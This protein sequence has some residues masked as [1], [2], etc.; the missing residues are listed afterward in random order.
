MFLNN[1]HKP[2]R[3]LPVCFISINGVQSVFSIEKKYE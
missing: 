3:K 2:F 1:L